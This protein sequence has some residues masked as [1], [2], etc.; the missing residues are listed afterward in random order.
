VKMAKDQKST[1]RKAGP[2]TPGWDA[3][4]LEDER[5]K[6]MGSG[7]SI[8]VIGASENRV[9]VSKS[10]A[11]HKY[12]HAFHQMEMEQALGS[13]DELIESQPDVLLVDLD[14]QAS[15]AFSLISELG[16]RN[17]SSTIMVYSSSQDP[18]LLVDSMRSGA[19]EFLRLPIQPDV[20]EDAMARVLARRGRNGTQPQQR[21]GRICVFWGAKGGV[22][23]TTLASNFAIALRRET[24]QRVALVDLNLHLGD[25]AVAL[26]LQA[27]FTVADAL[28]EAGRID[29]ELLTAILADHRSGISVLA[30]PD[31]FT[32]MPVIENGNLTKILSILR[33]QFTYVVVDT[34]PTL[35]IGAT[36]VLQ[37]ADRVYLVSDMG[38]PSL[39]SANRFATHVRDSLGE[40]KRID[41]VLNRCEKRNAEIDQESI[42]KALPLAKCWRVPND[43]RAVRECLNT[44]NPLDPHR[45][46]VAR[47]LHVMAREV[48]GKQIK[49][50]KKKWWE[51]M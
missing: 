25:V 44:G 10:V 20:L 38:I 28:K 22:G 17:S 19:R 18:S 40:D 41:L 47:A 30:G 50:R 16:Q 48:C 13:L 34:G 42:S 32:P 51:I 37:A 31:E 4:S 1:T 12:V 6:D 3:L 27:R 2:S 14:G 33:Q 46:P 39:R 29:E 21:M 45:S 26:G 15:E 36:S 7:L 43:Y 49:K 24:G 23:V 9:P 8:V 11:E 5:G 35:G